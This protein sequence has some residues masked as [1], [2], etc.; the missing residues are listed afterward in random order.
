MKDV[1]ERHNGF[2]L[3][4][5]MLAEMKNALQ[6]LFS[7]GAVVIIAA[8][9]KSC[10]YLLYK[11]LDVGFSGADEALGKLCEVLSE[12][13]WGELSIAQLDAEK[14]RGKIVARKSFE[15]RK[16]KASDKFGCYFLSNFMAGFLS[17]LFG[18][19]VTVREMKCSGRGDENCEFEFHP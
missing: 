18:R 1:L 12:W 10:G 8:M 11:K 7:S 9:A 13:N 2:F 19:E 3:E 6:Q 15:T 14:G 17:K 4:F 5:E 16:E